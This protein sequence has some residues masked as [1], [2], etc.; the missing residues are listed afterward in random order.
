[1]V[2]AGPGG[3]GGAGRGA[4]RLASG[5]GQPAGRGAAVSPRSPEKARN[6]V[7]PPAGGRAL[8][9]NLTAPPPPPP[10]PPPRPASGV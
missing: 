6:T 1:M 3:R 4:E 7:A 9:S 2:P 10:L 8:F 5:A